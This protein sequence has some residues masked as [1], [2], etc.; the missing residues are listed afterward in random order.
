[1]Y[2][3]KRALLNLA[4]PTH[5]SVCSVWL[6][7]LLI[8]LLCYHFEIFLYTDFLARDLVLRALLFFP[9]KHCIFAVCDFSIKL[10]EADDFST[11]FVSY[12]WLSGAAMLLSRFEYVQYCSKTNPMPVLYKCGHFKTICSFG[13]ATMIAF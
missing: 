12:T 13:H 2:V 11:N 6:P 7:H 8:L 9:P 5:K 4:G 1:M 3:L 10:A